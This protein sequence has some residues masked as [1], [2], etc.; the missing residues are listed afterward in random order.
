MVVLHAKTMVADGRVSIVGS[1]NLDHR[2]VEYN[3]E[4]SAI[5]RSAKFGKLMV[6]LFE[7]DVQYAKRI[8][9]AEWRRR[10][11]SDRIIQ[12]AVSRARYL[13]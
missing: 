13:M 12:W 10:P 4:V 2:S 11:N 1:T 3:C 9:P 6:D 7:N 5:I 8:D